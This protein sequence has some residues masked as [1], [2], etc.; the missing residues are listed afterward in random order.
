MNPG[1]ASK[2]DPAG[3]ERPAEMAVAIEDTDG[4]VICAGTGSA[5]MGQEGQG[6]CRERD[7]VGAQCRST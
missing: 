1:Y 2:P 5:P 7:G 3:L 6:K 4:L